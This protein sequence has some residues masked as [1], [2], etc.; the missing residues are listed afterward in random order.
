MK[1]K[2]PQFLKTQFEKKY[3]QYKKFPDEI[4]QFLLDYSNFYKWE[5]A[6]IRLIYNMIKK[7]F[8]EKPSCELMGC[9]LPCEISSDYVRFTRGC[10]RAHSQ[11]IGLLEKHGVMNSNQTKSAKEN[12]KKTNLKKY[13]VEHPQQNKTIK[14]KVTKTNLKKYGVANVAQNEQI[15]D[16]IKNSMI[17]KYGGYTLSSKILRNKYEETMIEKYGGKFPMQT[18]SGRN[19]IKQT[20]LEKYDVEWNLQSNFS[21]EKQQKSNLLKYGHIYAI[22]STEIKAKI[23]SAFM[24]KYGVQSPMQVPE[25]AEK[26]MESSFNYKEYKWK[27]GETVMVQGYEN[28]VLYELE[29]NGYSFKDIKTNKSDMPEI[30]YEF[31]GKRRRYYPDIFIPKENLIIEVKSD[32]TLNKEWEKNQA[33]FDATKNLGF[34]FKLD[35]R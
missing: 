19:K 7:G 12:A 29:E 14:E 3:P 32:Y 21:L 30:W 23:K 16:K 22:A 25:F 8:S 5:I 1:N 24:T 2:I 27:T 10:C 20:N 33:K 26:Q 6:D 34:N 13:G 18:E 15:K 28:I 9:N 35:V 4:N 11:S 17:E 31:E